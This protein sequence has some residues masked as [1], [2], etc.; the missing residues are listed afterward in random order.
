MNLFSN[1]EEYQDFIQYV[2]MRN[3]IFFR[4]KRR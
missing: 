4:R 3:K 1:D 2:K